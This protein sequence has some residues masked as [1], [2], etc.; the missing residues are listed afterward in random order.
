MRTNQQALNIILPAVK[1]Y[2]MNLRS[3]N[4]LFIYRDKGGCLDH[5]EASFIASNFLHLTGVEFFA[6]GAKRGREFYDKC[7]SNK[8]RTSDFRLRKDGTS[9]MKL[10]VLCSFMQLHINVRSVGAYDGSRIYL[11]SDI[12]AGN[13]VGCMGFCKGSSA[14]YAPNTLLKEAINKV[15]RNTNPVV[16]IYSKMI[17][18]SGYSKLRFLSKSA[19][20][21]HAFPT[22]IVQ[23]LAVKI[24]ND[25][26]PAQPDSY[27]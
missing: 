7:I 21:A 13:T 6:S 23:K 14:Y 15:A 25:F 5:F 24:E 11:R 17:R 12:M 16:A 3:H 1:I 22:P 18:E 27:R 9:D 2:D 4:Y 19:P 20:A 26:A 10:D 8:L